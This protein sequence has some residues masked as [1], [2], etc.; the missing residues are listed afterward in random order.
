M[1]L[2]KFLPSHCKLVFCLGSLPRSCP[3]C[4]TE[5]LSCHLDIP[6][7][8]LPTPF[9]RARDYP[10][11]I[12]IKPSKGEL[13]QSFHWRDMKSLLVLQA[14]SWRITTTRATSTSL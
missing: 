11:S 12:V 4:H 13:S 3:V 5:L 2:R 10:T 14:I 9:M 7:F 1:Q 8:A 6:P